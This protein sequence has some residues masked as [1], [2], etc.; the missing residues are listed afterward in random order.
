MRE[1]FLKVLNNFSA[2]VLSYLCIVYCVVVI[3][4]N[5]P[6]FDVGYIGYSSL[7]NDS[8]NRLACFSAAFKYSTRTLLSLLTTFL[9]N[10][11]E[12]N[13]TTA[14]PKPNSIINSNNL[15]K[16]LMGLPTPL[17]ARSATTSN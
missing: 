14:K 4:E 15:V 11:K 3:Y 17:Q 13:S 2:P 12:I 16:V 5:N 10:R 1:N 9:K 8:P 7:S 6:H